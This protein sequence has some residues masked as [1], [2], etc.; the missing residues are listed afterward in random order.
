MSFPDPLGPFRADG[1]IHARGLVS[2]DFCADRSPWNDRGALPDC[3][4]D[5]CEPQILG[6]DRRLSVVACYGQG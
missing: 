1:L 4:Q 6:A 3:L 2:S 5:R